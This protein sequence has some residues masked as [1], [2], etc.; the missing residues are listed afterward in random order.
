M[1]KDR[2]F[3]FE[4]KFINAIVSGRE[5]ERKEDIGHKVRRV[6]RGSQSHER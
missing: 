1:P 2:P 4:I 5:R 6:E 3:H